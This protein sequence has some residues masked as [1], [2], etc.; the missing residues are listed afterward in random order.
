MSKPV[1]V[2]WRETSEELRGRYVTEREVDRRKRLQV[3]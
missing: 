3:L 1:A 2:A